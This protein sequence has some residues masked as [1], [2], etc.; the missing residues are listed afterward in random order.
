MPNSVI[1]DATI[2]DEYCMH[3]GLSRP[4]RG[5]RNDGKSIIHQALKVVVPWGN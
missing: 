1:D 2:Q 4:V 5:T 3:S